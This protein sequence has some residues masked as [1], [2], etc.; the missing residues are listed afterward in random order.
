[1]RLCKYMLHERGSF[2]HTD[3]QVLS[4]S[5]DSEQ[6]PIR[7]KIA[8]LSMF[9]IWKNI[10]FIHLHLLIGTIYRG[11][12][13]FSATIPLTWSSMKVQPV[14]KKACSLLMCKWAT[15]G[16]AF[17]TQCFQECSAAHNRH[18][19]RE[20]ESSGLNDL[21]QQQQLWMKKQPLV[22]LL[23]RHHQPFSSHTRRQLRD[24]HK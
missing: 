4:I 23:S 20:D 16:S 19:G 5:F 18:L 14:K 7:A 13:L 17:D 12:L 10:V 15:T 3:Q 9:C 2:L 8:L 24:P 22:K 1:M 11:A 6:K 21:S